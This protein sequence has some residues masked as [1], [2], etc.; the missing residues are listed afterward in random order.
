MADH[1][2]KNR[3]PAD[4]FADIRDEIKALEK[5]EGQLRDVLINSDPDDRVGAD[6]YTSITVQKRRALDPDKLA[7]KFGKDAIA[8]C[9]TDKDVTYVKA[10]RRGEVE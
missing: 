1:L 3:H 5:R 9:Y 8:D 2:Q 6:S 7:A 4:E 10:H